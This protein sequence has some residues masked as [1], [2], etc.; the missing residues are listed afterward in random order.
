MSMMSK[1][2]E[3][4][5]ARAFSTG[6]TKNEKHSILRW[7]LDP[8]SIIIIFTIIVTS[9]A[10][11]V[12]RLFNDTYAWMHPALAAIIAGAFTA[13]LI[14]PICAWADNKY[15][16]STSVLLG[17]VTASFTVYGAPLRGEVVAP[18]IIAFYAFHVFF[19]Y[20]EAEALW[21]P[22]Y[23]AYIT[24]GP[25]EVNRALSIESQ[26]LQKLALETI[27]NDLLEYDN[28]KREDDDED[29]EQ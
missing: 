5:V 8:K 29:E 27:P 9:L 20:A 16:L 3:A 14:F 7:Y 18:L 15:G 4:E 17:L 28:E 19:A 6:T 24:Q 11:P 23:E 22:L 21:P 10:L 26:E 2:G 25:P 1:E 12:W 13:L